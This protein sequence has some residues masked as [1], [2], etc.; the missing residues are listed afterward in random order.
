MLDARFSTLDAECLSVG[1]Y[2]IVDAIIN[3]SDKLMQDWAKIPH[4]VEWHLKSQIK[5]YLVCRDVTCYIPISHLYL[6]LLKWISFQNY[7]FSKETRLIASVQFKKY[8]IVG[9]F[10]KRAYNKCNF[11]DCA[12]SP[13]LGKK[14][15]I[16]LLQP[17]LCY[18]SKILK[19]FYPWIRRIDTDF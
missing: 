16:M 15:F 4:F 6:K 2:A 9:L 19:N 3:F 8:K 10:V 12:T 5:I 7:Y 17:K 1:I 13:Y 14:R 11:I 18:F